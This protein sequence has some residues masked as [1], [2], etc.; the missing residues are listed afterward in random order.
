MAKLSLRKHLFF[1]FGAYVLG[2]ITSAILIFPLAPII[3]A[4]SVIVIPLIAIPIVLLLL[5]RQNIEDNL[6]TWCIRAPFVITASYII[7][8]YCINHIARTDIRLYILNISLWYSLLLPLIISFVI[9][10]FYIW[11]VKSELIK[12]QYKKQNDV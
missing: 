1:L 10:L 6:G 12:I 8:D 5:Y 3:L 7:M 11:F 9:S 2:F 4:G